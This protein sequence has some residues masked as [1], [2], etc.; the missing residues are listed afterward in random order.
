MSSGHIPSGLRV[1]TLVRMLYRF[2]MTQSQPLP[3][4]GFI[5]KTTLESMSSC[6]VSPVCG[7]VLQSQ[8]QRGRVVIYG[9]PRTDHSL[10]HFPMRWTVTSPKPLIHGQLLV[11]RL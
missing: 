8:A 3:P 4:L 1:L 7:L 9:P 5:Y 6:L 11:T 10:L 2:S